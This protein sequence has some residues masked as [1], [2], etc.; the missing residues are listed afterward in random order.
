MLAD[1]ERR[2]PSYI[3]NHATTQELNTT[4]LAMPSTK[5]SSSPVHIAGKMLPQKLALNRSIRLG[6]YKVA[7]DDPHE[8][9]IN[10]ITAKFELWRKMFRDF[11]TG[12]NSRVKVPPVGH[13]ELAFED[14]MGTSVWQDEQV[15]L[16][17]R[18]YTDPRYFYP[19]PWIRRHIGRVSNHPQPG[20]GV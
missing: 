1:G 18:N 16:K 2:V 6:F 17:P 5:R 8:P 7:M 19:P 10:K 15:Y 11:G 13:V 12:A 3:R 4:P 20:G 14:G 9:R